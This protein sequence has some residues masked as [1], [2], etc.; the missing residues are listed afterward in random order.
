MPVAISIVV[1]ELQAAKNFIC[2]SQRIIMNSMKASY[3]AYLQCGLQL[4][5]INF[6][7]KLRF[8][9]NSSRDSLKWLRRFCGTGSAKMSSSSA[10]RASSNSSTELSESISRGLKS[11]RVNRSISTHWQRLTYTSLM[12]LLSASLR[13]S[14]RLWTGLMPVSLNFVVFVELSGHPTHCWC[15]TGILSTA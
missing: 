12:K 5:I 6:E 15:L 14:W 8:V 10:F 2:K 1:D 13:E 3:K 9:R 7:I 4:K 11:S